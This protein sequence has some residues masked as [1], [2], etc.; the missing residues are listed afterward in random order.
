M[1]TGS[2]AAASITAITPAGRAVGQ[3]IKLEGTRFTGATDVKFGS[4]SATSIVVISDTIIT[5]V[6]PAGTGVKAITVITPDGTSPA[7]NYT[8]A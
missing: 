8:V 2:S 6:I 7:V 4:V 1:D 3:A 5:A